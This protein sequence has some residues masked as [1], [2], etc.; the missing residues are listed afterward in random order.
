[1]N[2]DS[3]EKEMYKFEIEALCDKYKME[4]RLISLNA[5]YPSSEDDSADDADDAEDELTPGMIIVFAI[6]F[7]FSIICASTVFG[8][9]I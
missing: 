4:S 5:L 7:F 1:M 3:E 2:I 8:M 9:G 6:V